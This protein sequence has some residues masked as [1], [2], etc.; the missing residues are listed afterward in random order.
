MMISAD[1][2]KQMTS[3]VY[4]VGR[5][6]DNL[7]K[8][9][10][11]SQN[12]IPDI[13]LSKMFADRVMSPFKQDVSLFIE[14][15][16]GSG[17]SYASL[18]IAYLT[19]TAIANARGGEWT[20]YFNIETNVAIISP[21]D[22][23]NVMQSLKDYNV[24]ILDDIGVG[25]NARTFQQKENRMM[26]DIF[27]VCR[28]KRN[29]IIFSAPAAFLIDKVPREL[30]TYRAEV[31]ESVH[32]KGFSTIK[33]KSPLR[34]SQ[35]DKTISPYLTIGRNRIVRFLIPKPPEQLAERYDVLRAEKT[36]AL[37][38][39]HANE[40]DA[41]EEANSKETMKQLSEDARFYQVAWQHEALGVPLKE[42][43]KSVGMGDNTYRSI[44]KKKNLH[45]IT[46]T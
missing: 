40:M 37:I 7:E 22:A 34:I 35:L 6:R 17:K 8:M 5:G 20:D 1:E 36:D 16:K 28:V 9:V 29:V 18:S 31:A 32:S 42:A 39:D 12:Q 38:K 19:A 27:E 23:Y 13:S 10:K 41:D 30:A 2:I 15:R 14:G 21:E 25:W 43:C 24:Y 46:K 3:L 4:G 33:L 45:T 26:N 44:R 11:L